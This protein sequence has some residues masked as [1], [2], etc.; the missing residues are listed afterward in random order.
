LIEFSRAH[1][2]HAWQRPSGTAFSRAI[3]IGGVRMVP[4]V[5][6]KGARIPAIGL[7]TMTL[8]GDICVEA[9]AAALKMGYRHIDTAAFYDNEAEVGEGIRKSGVP[10]DEIFLTTKVRHIDLAPGDFEASVEASLKRLDLPHVDLL[11]IHWPNPDIPPEI[12]IPALC[13]AKRNGQTRHIGVANFTMA[14]LEEAEKLADEPIVN[15]QIETHPF[16]DHRTILAYCKGRGISVTGYCPLGRG[17]IPG[18][19]VLERVAK[20]HNKSEAQIALR[21]L[22]QEGVI[23]IPRTASPEKLKANVDI[24]DFMLAD[25]EMTEIRNLAEPNGRIVKP[26]QSPK[27]DS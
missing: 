16:L 21:F 4:V 7:G 5:E 11:L 8:K 2:G 26:A 20:T 12:Y 18:N 17:R 3:E 15:N 10:R 22:V 6:V 19:A 13:K 23:P 1:R 14:L 27:W 24:F 9:V 25:S